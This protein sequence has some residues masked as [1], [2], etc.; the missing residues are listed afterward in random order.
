[1]RTSASSEMNVTSFFEVRR[2]SGSATRTA[3]G[4]HRAPVAVAKQR[5]GIVRREMHEKTIAGALLAHT[6]KADLSLKCG[7]EVAEN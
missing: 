2:K 1:M 7:C 5:G 3:P 6:G 4:P